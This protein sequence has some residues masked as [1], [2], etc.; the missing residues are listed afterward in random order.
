M[1][2]QW[3]ESAQ[4]C[5]NSMSLEYTCFGPPPSQAPTLVLLH[6]G[7]GSAGLWRDFPT[8]LVES[9]GFGVFAYSRAGYGRSDSVTLPRPLNYM[10]C[11]ATDI[12]PRVLDAIGFSQGILIGHSD[13]AT[14][15]AIHAG[16]VRDP[17][18]QGIVLMAPHFFTEPIALSAISD[19]K[20]AYENLDLRLRL[21]KYHHD[22]DNAFY[23]WNDSWLHPD[24]AQWE[25]SSVLESLQVPVL[26]IQGLQDQYGSLAQIDIIEH[27]CPTLVK[28]LLLDDCRHSPFLDCP[29]EVLVEITRFCAT[30]ATTP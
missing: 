5:A 30:V 16:E 21:A 14:I 9:T 29:S 10:T 24:F 20:L 4:L 3:V 11:E 7:L 25:V 13:G 12:L 1:S 2:A 18:V 8:Q 17:R 23:G 28:K 6:E 27:K 19:A 15:A 26:A 22:P